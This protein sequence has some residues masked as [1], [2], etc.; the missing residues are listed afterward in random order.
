MSEFAA[1]QTGDIPQ[2]LFMISGVAEFAIVMRGD[3]K[4]IVDQLFAFGKRDSITDPVF[5]GFVGTKIGIESARL[6]KRRLKM[7]LSGFAFGSLKS[8]FDF[9]VPG[10]AKIGTHHF[11]SGVDVFGDGDMFSLKRDGEAGFSCG[12]EPD[13]QIVP[14]KPVL[15]ESGGGGHSP[16]P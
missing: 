7:E 13:H 3:E 15:F 5:A 1:C 16:A 9:G 4:G 10:G 12:G 2:K 11:D 8:R 6:S 14:E